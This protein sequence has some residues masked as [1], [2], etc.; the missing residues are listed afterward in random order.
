MRVTVLQQ[1]FKAPM[2]PR[3]VVFYARS[4]ATLHETIQEGLAQETLAPLRSGLPLRSFGAD[5]P[6]HETVFLADSDRR[7]SGPY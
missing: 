1:F 7:N 3:E 6:A 4:Q 2:C 5:G